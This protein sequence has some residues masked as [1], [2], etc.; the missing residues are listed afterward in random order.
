MLECGPAPNSSADSATKLASRVID[1]HP[2][3]PAALRIT[4]KLYAHVQLGRLRSLTP[5]LARG[6]DVRLTTPGSD[7]PARSQMLG[8]LLPE[9][10]IDLCPRLR[11]TAF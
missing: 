10:G 7:G 3:W 6:A 1:D 11:N 9:S 8:I 2:A 5:E 4:S